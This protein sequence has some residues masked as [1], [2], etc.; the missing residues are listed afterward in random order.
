VVYE[1]VVLD[2]ARS[3]FIFNENPRPAQVV[4]WDENRKWQEEIRNYRTKPIKVEIRHVL[5]GDVQF[6]MEGAKG[7]KLYDFQT[8]E[9]LLD[10]KAHTAQKYLSE[11]LFHM[12]QNQKQNRVELTTK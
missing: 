4:G 2:L 3:N 11:G 7:L 9:Y 8:P 10:L 5:P 6:S 12:G 1:R